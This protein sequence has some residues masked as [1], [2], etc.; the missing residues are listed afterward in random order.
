MRGSEQERKGS[1]ILLSMGRSD[2]AREIREN[3][4]LRDMAHM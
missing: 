3:G 2:H 4:T 1:T